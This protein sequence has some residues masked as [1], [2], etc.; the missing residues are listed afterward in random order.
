[1]KHV[2]TKAQQHPSGPR[3]PHYRGFVITLRH[4]ELGRTSLDEWSARRRNL[5]LTPHNTQKT[6]T[7]M[8]PEGFEPA[9]GASERPQNHALD[10]A[11]TGIGIW[12][13]THKYIKVNYVRRLLAAICFS[14]SIVLFKPFLC[15]CLMHLPLVSLISY[16]T[17]T[18]PPSVNLCTCPFV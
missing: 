9:T 13:I 6:Q 2:F 18:H 15:K 8:P 16:L 17:H 10:R 11:A 7:S 14:P 12:N 5:Y 3:S 4:T 1:M